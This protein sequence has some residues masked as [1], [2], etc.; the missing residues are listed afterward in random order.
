[1]QIFFIKAIQG[2]RRKWMMSYFVQLKAS[3]A[4]FLTPFW[5]L[6]A[7]IFL[8]LIALNIL[9]TPAAPSDEELTTKS[10]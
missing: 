10:H 5:Y 3:K 8:F 2:I 4:L 6:I 9:I 7:K 1:L